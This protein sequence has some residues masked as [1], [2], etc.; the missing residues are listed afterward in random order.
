LSPVSPTTEQILRLFSHAGRHT[1]LRDDKPVQ[2]FPPQLTAIQLQT[3]DLLGVPAQAFL[4]ERVSSSSC[5]HTTFLTAP[6]A[7]QTTIRCTILISPSIDKSNVI[8]IGH[9][10]Q[11]FI[12]HY[13]LEMVVY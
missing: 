13:I 4:F 11:I 5:S 2:S 9:I 7:D 12:G 8:W 3:L 1:L 10:I 6:I